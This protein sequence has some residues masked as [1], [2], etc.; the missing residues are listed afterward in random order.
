MDAFGVVVEGQPVHQPEEVEQIRYQTAFLSDKPLHK[1]DV[2]G[3]IGGYPVWG[4][5]QMAKL[6][7]RRMKLISDEG[8]SFG[9]IQG[10]QGNS[11]SGPH[12]AGVA[13]LM[14]SVNPEL[15]P[16]QVKVLMEKTCKDLGKSGRDT[17]YGAGL[18]DAL[19]AVRA[20][21]RESAN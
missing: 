6:A 16:W 21:K 2:P 4:R 13:A 5:P 12:A 7:P 18:L 20:A 8:N 10:P 1:P 19:E 14:L 11:F 17:Q 3:C 15:H 9:L